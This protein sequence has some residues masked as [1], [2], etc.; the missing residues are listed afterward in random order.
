MVGLKR[1]LQILPVRIALCLGAVLALSIPVG[2]ALAAKDGGLDRAAK[3][4]VTQTRIMPLSEVEAGMEGYG[5]T[6]FRG[7]EPERFV[8]A[9]I[10]LLTEDG[11]QGL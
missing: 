8:V 2:V 11:Q 3:K 5:L 6:V 4:K 9:D 10:L 1:A 7:T